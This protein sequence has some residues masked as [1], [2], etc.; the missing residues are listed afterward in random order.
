MTIYIPLLYICIALECKFFQSEIYTLDKQKCEQEI[1]QQKI[2]IIKLGNKV[3][4][5][6]IDM[7]IKLE[8][9]QDLY[10][11]VYQTLNNK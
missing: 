11:T 1:A 5:I 6:C 8:K 3:E 7:D 9:K 2:E 4:A 10:N